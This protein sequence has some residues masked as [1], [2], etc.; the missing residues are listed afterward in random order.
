[1]KRQSLELL[2]PLSEI[3]GVKLNKI[4]GRIF[5]KK[6]GMHDEWVHVTKL[7]IHGLCCKLQ[8]IT[9]NFIMAC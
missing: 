3:V 8:K 6:R 5:V 1:M 2:I 9:Q 4:R 7:I